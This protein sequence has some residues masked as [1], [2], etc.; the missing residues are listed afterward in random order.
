ML[1]SKR[2]EDALVFANRLHSEQQRKVSG[3]PYVGHLLGVASI[4]IE[5]G[6]TENEA[7]AALLH[8][9]VEDQEV[10]KIREEIRK[11]FGDAVVEIVDGCT[12]SDVVPK[13]P[14]RKRKED[15]IR[16]FAE[17]SPSILLV[18]ASDKLQNARA[19][20]EKYRIIGDEIWNYFEGKKD[21]MLWYYRALVTSFR[22]RI[23]HVPNCSPQIVRIIDELDRVV[24]ELELL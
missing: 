18:S 12:D 17:A 20:L 5:H 23:S 1:Y 9:A 8:D 21:G 14:W 4:V 15:Y 22:E 13:P 19:T 10:P 16:H 24:T 11:R 6:G 2:F 3:T 7:I